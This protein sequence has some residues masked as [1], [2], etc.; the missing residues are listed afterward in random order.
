MKKYGLLFSR[1]F[2]VRTSAVVAV[3]VKKFWNFTTFWYRFDWP[4]GKPGLKSSIGNFEY[5]LPHELS[6][7]VGLRNLENIRKIS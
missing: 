7:H 3:L 2:Y 1:K 6:N 5:E 4:Q